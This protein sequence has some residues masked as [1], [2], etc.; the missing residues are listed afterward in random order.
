MICRLLLS[1][2]ESVYCM[3][4]STCHWGQWRKTGY[5]FGKPSQTR[6]PRIL[7]G[8]HVSAP[9]PR[10]CLATVWFSCYIQSVGEDLDWNNLIL[11]CYMAFLYTILGTIITWLMQAG[12]FDVHNIYCAVYTTFIEEH[13]SSCDGSRSRLGHF[14]IVARWIRL[15]VFIFCMPHVYPP[16]LSYKSTCIQISKTAAICA[17]LLV[18]RNKCT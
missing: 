6:R 7:T 1:P 8:Y 15:F 14:T 5:V 2:Q 13:H 12:P 9:V 18:I 4:C 16:F 17:R 3:D 10:R 11:L